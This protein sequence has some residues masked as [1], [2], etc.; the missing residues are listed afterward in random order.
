MS[1]SFS[2]L[3]D[4]APERSYSK[5]AKLNTSSENTMRETAPS[6]LTCRKSMEYQ[7]GAQSPTNR[8]QE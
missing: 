1:A 8:K 2:N 5:K 6:S 7:P 3:E 4:P